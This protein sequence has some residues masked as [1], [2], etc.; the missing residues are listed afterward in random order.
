[1][2]TSEY[3]TKVG[4][5]LNRVSNRAH[6]MFLTGYPRSEIEAVCKEMIREEAG[7]ILHPKPKTL[8]DYISDK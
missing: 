8:T 2:T 6:H 7:H 5:L 4:S 3:S 1:M